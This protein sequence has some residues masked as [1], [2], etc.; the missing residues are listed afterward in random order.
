MN[1]PQTMLIHSVMAVLLAACGGG[2][3]SSGSGG[4]TAQIPLPVPSPTPTASPSPSPATGGS[5]Q[6][7]WAD[8]FNAASVD[9]TRWNLIEDCWGGGN[10]ERQC[11][12]ARPEN[13]S[14]ANGHLV[15]TAREESWTGDAWSE[16]RKLVV[17]DPDAQKT[18]EFTSGKLTTNGK[19]SWRYGRLERRARLPQGQG[20]WP[21]FWIM[22]E[23]NVYG[24]WAASGELDILEVVNLGVVCDDCPDG[25]ENRVYGSLHFGGQWPDNVFANR[26]R[27]SPEILAGGFHVYGVIWEEGRITWTLDGQPYG[28]ME[29]AEWY[30]SASNN[31]NA[32]FDEKFHLIV[33]FAVGGRWPE[34][35]GV[36]GV[37]RV[38]FPKSMEIDWIRVYQCDADPETG[39]GCS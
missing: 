11:Y 32:P 6:L 5:W 23:E 37:S 29:A 36:G 21:A 2:S 13:I 10:D 18:Q 26:R 25:G 8:E 1:Y 17:A 24:T 31:P 19:H 7:V 35:E 38:N 4:G 28:S 33:N 27:E 14:L 12:T 39:K 30:T 22:P 34:S 16:E 3:G 15:I 20:S 9:E